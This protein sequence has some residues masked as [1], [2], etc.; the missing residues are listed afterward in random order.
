MRAQKDTG[1]IVGTVKE[2]TGAVVPNADVEVT[3]VER[4]QTFKT[5]TSDSGEFAA[6][7]LHVGRYKVAW[8]GTVSPA[9]YCRFRTAN[10][11]RQS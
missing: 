7:R 3:D 9:R 5:T 8:R 4:G 11:T 2:G 6:S 1:S 10:R